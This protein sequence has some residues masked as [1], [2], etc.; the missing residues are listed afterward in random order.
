MGSGRVVALQLPVVSSHV[1]D[2]TAFRHAGFRG[3]IDARWHRMR[4][5]KDVPMI[6]SHCRMR[7]YQKQGQEMMN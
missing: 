5:A 1:V 6:A 7:N 2:G 3:D 4:E